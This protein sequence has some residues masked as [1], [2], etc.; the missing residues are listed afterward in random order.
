MIRATRGPILVEPPSSAV[1]LAPSRTFVSGMFR[2]E[3]DALLY[4][5]GGSVELRRECP[6]DEEARR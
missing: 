4:V 3:P 5:P 6:R 2:E 1:D